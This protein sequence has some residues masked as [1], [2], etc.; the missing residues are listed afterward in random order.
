MITSLKHYLPT[1]SLLLALITTL[2]APG[3]IAAEQEDIFEVLRGRWGGSG[4]MHLTQNRRERLVCDAQYSG[5]ATQ[6]RIVIKC[7]SKFE[8]ID[9]QATLSANERRLAGVWE[10]KAYKA[11]GT[12]AG[13]A[14]EGEIKFYVGGNVLGTMTVTYNKRRQKVLIETKGIPMQ[15]LQI[16]MT[17]R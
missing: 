10:E 8:N 17:R 4:L 3:S 7:R 13:Q 1:Y 14:A 2:H 6:L 11:I 12:I 9:L 16:D 5:S 15:K